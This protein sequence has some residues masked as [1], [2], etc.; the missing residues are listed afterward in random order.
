MDDDIKS[1]DVTETPADVSRRAFIKVI[2]RGTLRWV[3]VSHVTVVEGSLAQAGMSNRPI[4]LN[5]NGQQ[6][7]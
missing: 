7:C 3:S 4:T 2:G 6:W 1:N 5:V